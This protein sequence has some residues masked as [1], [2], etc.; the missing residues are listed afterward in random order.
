MKRAFALV[1]AAVLSGTA[2]FAEED[3]IK[4]LTY[5]RWVDIGAGRSVSQLK[6]AEI[7]QLRRCKDWTMYFVPA[8]AGVDQIFVV[9]MTMTTGFPKVLVSRIAGET[10][11]ILSQEGRE[12][13]SDTL[14]LSK[15]GNVLTQFSPPFRPHTYLRCVDAKKKP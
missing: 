2:A 15:D 8:G 5:A 7:A 6:P 1:L 9:G 4:S 10:V 13:P 3:A 14:H 11:F 12:K